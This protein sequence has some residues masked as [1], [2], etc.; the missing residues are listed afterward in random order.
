MPDPYLLAEPQTSHPDAA[1]DPAVDPALLLEILGQAPIVFHRIF[2]DITGSVTAALW[3]SYA[4]YALEAHPAHH[5][6]WFSKSQD[7]WQRDTGLTRREQ[8]TARRR[9]RVLELLE[10]RRAMNLPLAFRVDCLRLHAL[11]DTHARRAHASM[12]IDERWRGDEAF[13]HR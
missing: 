11:I 13:G 6:G 1:V 9:L 7:E 8:E 5:D 12:P 10:E 2:V 3:L 4:L